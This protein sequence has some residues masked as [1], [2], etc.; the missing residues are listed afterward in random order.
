MSDSFSASSDPVA[1]DLSARTKLRLTGADRV[2][3]LH[4]QVSSDVRALRAGESQYACVMTA[5]GKMCADI[6]VHA[7]PEALLLDADPSLREELAARL[8]RYLIADDVVMTDVTDELALLHVIPPRPDGRRTQRLGVDGSDHFVPVSER[9]AFLAELALPLLSEAE[10]ELRR[11]AAG[12]PRWGL[13]LA[14]D[15]IPVEAGL[16]ERALCYTKGCYIGQEVISR[17]K[18]IGQVNHRLVRLRSAG[19]LTVG[20]KLLDAAGATT[21]EVTSAIADPHGGWLGLGYVRRAQTAAGTRVRAG[22][23]EAEVW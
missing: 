11:I 7:E 17:L 21:G 14:P 22:E 4:G 1:L 16:E 15:T 3:F 9:A 6:F 20:E 18:S 10:Q 12:V 5:K 13:D 19:E 2:R 8:E 23:S